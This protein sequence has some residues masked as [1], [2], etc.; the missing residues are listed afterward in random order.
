MKNIR[1]FSESLDIENKKVIVRSDFNVP[2][3]NKIIQDKTRI[4]LSIPFIQNLLDRKAKVLLISHLGRPK[5]IKDTSLSLKPVFSYLQE[6]IK[7]KIHFY[8]D[9]ITQ[10]T[11]AR[12]SFLSNSEIIFFENIRFNEG[13]ITDDENFAKNLSSF[14]DIYIN[15]AFSCSHRKQTSV[16]K[17]TKYIKNSFAGPL[18][19]KEIHSIS[20]V[21]D[22]KKNP[23]T[24]IIGGSKITTKLGVITSLIKKIDNLIIVGAMANNFVKFMGNNVGKS[25]TE[26]GTE[27]VIKEIYNLARQNNCKIITPIDFA[28]SETSDGNANFKNLKNVIDNEIILDIGPK[29]IEKIIKI[30]DD[31]KTVLWNGPAGYFENKNFSRGTVSIAKK[32]SDNTNKAVLISIVGGGDTISAI[33]NNA[34]DLNFTHLSTAG[35]AFLEYIEGKNLPGI[36][37]LK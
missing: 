1:S 29:T 24:C 22:N 12:I 9:K 18:F 23:T 37:V 8:S 36:E 33:R 32:I 35:G 31:S 15:D 19:M 21:L 17:I 2:I 34:L 14:G 28:V 5:N 11:K 10:E 26:I 25:L 7:N 3:K 27:K 13:E 16:H 20:L 6:K 30:I 4:N